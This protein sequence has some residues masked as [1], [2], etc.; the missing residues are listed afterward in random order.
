[1]A[2]QPRPPRPLWR[3]WRFYVPAI[4]IPVIGIVMGVMGPSWFGEKLADF[5]MSVQPMSLTTYPGGA[6]QTQVNVAD[7]HGYD[8]EVLLSCDEQPPGIIVTFIPLGGPKPSY[9]STIT[10]TV[11]DGVAPGDYSVHITG[12]GSSG[13]RHDCIFIVTVKPPP[14]PTPAETVTVSSTVTTTAPP[15]TVTGTTPAPEPQAAITYPRDNTEVS[16][17]ESVLGT[18][19]DIPAG[20]ELWLIVYLP[21]TH[22]Y[23]PHSAPVNLEPNG[24]WSSP[25]YIGGPEDAGLTAHVMLYLVDTDAG[26]ALRDYLTASEADQE[27]PGLDGLPAGA[28]QQDSVKVT[29]QSAPT[30]TPTAKGTITYPLANSSVSREETLTGTFQDLPEDA[31]LWIFVYIPSIGRYYPQSMPV[32]PDGNGTWSF[33]TFIGGPNDA[34]LDFEL[35][36]VLADPAATQALLDYQAAQ[37]GAGIPSLPAGAAE[38]DRVPV[39]RR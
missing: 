2:T 17:Y 8:H 30:T 3:D 34:G 11:K 26:Q 1:M 13:E 36:L 25:L 15:Q 20:S 7:V 19:S 23:Y 10:V 31:G 37:P 22:R 9:Q 4:L 38:L 39:T 5:A 27:W 33:Y 32:T 24:D 16:G 35:V 18:S 12:T 29:R 21:S 6:V 14:T 28:A